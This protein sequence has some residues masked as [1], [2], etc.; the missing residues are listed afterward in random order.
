[1]EPTVSILDF[2]KSGPLDIVAW[3]DDSRNTL[4]HRQP[5]DGKE[6]KHDAGLIVRKTQ[7][8]QFVATGKYA[9]LSDARRHSARS[10]GRRALL[11]AHFQL[12]TRGDRRELDPALRGP[13]IQALDED[14]TIHQFHRH[15]AQRVAATGAG[16]AH[17]LL[18][19]ETRAVRGADQQTVF[20]H[21]EFAGRPVEAAARMRADVEPGADAAAAAVE[22]QRLGHAIDLGFDLQQPTVGQIVQRKQRLG[23][24]GLGI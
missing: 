13:L 11:A 7:H 10:A 23:D 22:N 9:D 21:Q 16:D 3:T 2:I 17:P 24:S 18:Q 12:R 5:D 4:S 20:R 8:V 14:R 15:R 1:M 19:L 6:N